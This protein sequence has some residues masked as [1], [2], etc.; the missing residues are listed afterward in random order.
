M[1]LNDTYTKSNDPVSGTDATV[2]RGRLP[3]VTNSADVLVVRQFG[4]EDKVELRYEHHLLENEDPTIEDSAYHKPGALVTWWFSPARYA[5]EVEGGGTVS[6][7]DRS[8]NFETL[9]ARMRLTRRVGRHFDS[10]VEYSHSATDFLDTGTD[11]QVYN[12][13]AGFIWSVA[14]DTEF[15]FGFGYFCRDAETGDTDDGFSGSVEMRH[16]W[17]N[18]GSLTLNGDRGYDRAYFGAENL[19]F[20][21]Y[22]EVSGSITQQLTRRI[23][24]QVT[25]GF[26]DTRYV[27]QAPD[28]K[29]TL[30]RAGGSLTFQALPWLAFQM[31]YEYRQLDSSTDLN[32]YKENRGSLT[33]SLTPRKPIRL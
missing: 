29:D 30:T 25:A 6:D 22:S 28:R 26:R 31:N 14:A 33:V 10:Y 15:S 17:T 1:E 4:I 27:D 8:E 19:G 32:D 9:D 5:V 12:P 13:M 3:H 18:H 20:N 24:G 2:R 23:T 7:F 21:P 11:Y 16:D